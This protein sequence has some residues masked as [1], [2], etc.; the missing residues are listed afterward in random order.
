MTEA[1]N[2]PQTM[3]SSTLDTVAGGR[4]SLH[5]V[6]HLT[7]PGHTQDF[8][9]TQQICEYLNA[10]H[11]YADDNNRFVE[12]N[13]YCT[14]VG[15]NFRQCLIYDSAAKDAKLIGVEYMIPKH[16]RRLCHTVV[17][18]HARLRSGRRCQTRRSNTGTHTSGAQGVYYLCA[19]LMLPQ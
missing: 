2:K 18:S 1:I 12:A 17:Q 13:H 8:T 19:L 16:V 4:D 7:G 15:E 9:P 5:L 14:H 10:F 11:V 3:L 6:H